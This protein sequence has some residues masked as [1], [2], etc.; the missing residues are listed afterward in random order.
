VTFAARSIEL[1][2]LV[3]DPLHRL[4][5]R[6]SGSRQSPFGGRHQVLSGGLCV[7]HTFR[8]AG[9]GFLRLPVPVAELAR[10]CERVTG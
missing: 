6:C 10:S 4:W 9:I 3:A 5:S 2:P 7:P 1:F 8:R